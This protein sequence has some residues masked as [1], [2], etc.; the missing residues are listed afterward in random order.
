MMS[1]HRMIC[2]VIAGALLSGSIVS[3]ATK[4]QRDER[5]GWWRG[6]D[7]DD[8]LRALK[9]SLIINNRVDKGRKGMQGMNKTDEFR[10]DFGTPEQEIPYNGFPGIDWES[11]M[12]MN[13]TWGFKASDHNWKSTEKLIRNLVDIAS[14]G[15]ATASLL[16]GG[17]ALTLKPEKDA[18]TILVPEKAPDPIDS[19]I[20]VKIDGAL[21]QQ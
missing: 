8:Y 2:G 15:G 4:A 14:K 9:P 7:L 6:M 1:V 20:A 3:A 21:Q 11:C 5:M 19:V 10:G 16:A 13:G 18:L 12:T 17:K